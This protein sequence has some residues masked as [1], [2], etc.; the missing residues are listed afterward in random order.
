MFRVI[1]LLSLMLLVL[2]CKPNSPKDE[3][4]LIEFLR[5][6]GSCSEDHVGQVESYAG[7][8]V[9]WYNKTRDT[10]SRYGAVHNWT[11]IDVDKLVARSQDPYSYVAPFTVEFSD[12]S[13]D[14]F[15]GQTMGLSG[16]STHVGDG[17]TEGPSYRATC[18]LTVLER[19]DHNPRLVK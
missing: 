1:A 12:I 2:G 19:L 17:E 9:H 13:A 7:D 6:E 18:R 4:E 14:Q 11:Q 15:A 10:H 3:Y 8:L 16:V 5:V